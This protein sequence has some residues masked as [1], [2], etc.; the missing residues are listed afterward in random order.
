MSFRK[1][2]ATDGCD[3]GGWGGRGVRGVWIGPAGEPRGWAGSD[4]AW[5]LLCRSLPSSSRQ[6]TRWW[7]G[8]A[9]T[10]GKLQVIRTR[11]LV[12]IGDVIGTGA[13]AAYCCWALFQLC[14]GTSSPVY[15]KRP[16]IQLS[17]PNTFLVSRVYCKATAPLGPKL[18]KC[19][20]HNL[21]WHNDWIPMSRLS[22]KL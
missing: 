1:Y 5:H 22:H 19:R 13:T 21:F 17:G 9:N 8:H 6:P 16:L 3:S 14:G 7:P 10:T 4:C 20:C 2:W 18:E 11:P 12:S 15:N